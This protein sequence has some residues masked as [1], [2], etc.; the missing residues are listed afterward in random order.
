[1]VKFGIADDR[2]V[3]V[4]LDTDAKNEVDD[5]FAIVQAVLTEMMD[6]KA[7]VA[8]HFG[9]EKSPHSMQD[10]FDE[11]HKVLGLMHKE[12]EFN[13]L[14]GGE[15]AMEAEDEIVVSEGARFIVE[16]AMKDDERPLYIAFLGP[17]T[18]MAAALLMEPR[19]A[20]KNV[21]VIWIGG[22]DWP[23][24]GWEYNLKNDIKA[25]NVVFKSEIELWQVPRNVYR[26]MPVSFAEMWD[27]VH[28][29]GEIGKYLVEN[30]IEFNNAQK[31]RPVEHR[32]LG[33]SPAVGI[34]IF[35]DCGE[36]EWKPAPVFDE[37]M[38]Y[39]HTGKYRPIKVYKNIDSRF[40]LEDFYAKIRL[41]TQGQVR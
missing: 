2:K 37:Q 34:I 40:I 9:T 20:K 30:V 31:C 19:I 36:W 26:M 11:I 8:A 27:K 12:N 4:I 33:D 35:N 13:V 7:I 23:A 5:Q 22:R 15:R 3:R 10:S 17:L 38:N 14:K 25:A 1:M 24:G 39:V 21:I 16:E 41:E 32:G 28:P 18:D 29:C 6:I